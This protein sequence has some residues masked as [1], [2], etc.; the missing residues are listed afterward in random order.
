MFFRKLIY[1]FAIR[2]TTKYLFFTKMANLKEK[3]FGLIDNGAST[4]RGLLDTINETIS[5]IDW[6]SQ[7]DSLN[8]MKNSLIKRGNELLGDFNELMK[9]V[10]NN[11]TDFEVTVPFD[12]SLG[13]KFECEVKDGKLIIE[14]SFEDENTTRNN[15]TVVN[16][17]HNCDVEKLEQKYNSLS[18]TM[19]VII[20]KIIS[21][22]KKEEEAKPR[23]FKLNTATAT[24]KREANKETHQAE[25]KLL[26]KFH[27]STGRTA[28][29]LPR[30]ANGRFV[31][32]NPK[33]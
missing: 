18:K 6:D 11:L 2:Q 1:I 7:F 21:E 5:E 29:V 23:K 10:K 15:K 4:A 28:R 31:R 3:L 22:P 9:Q 19:S 33:D 25:S 8:E 32:R 12:E 24:P 27:E 17:P 13:E 26:K 16:I 30:A 14:V 20:P